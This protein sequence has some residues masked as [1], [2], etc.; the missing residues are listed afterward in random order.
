MNNAFFWVSECIAYIP[1]DTENATSIT[2]Y[3]HWN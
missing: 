3:I 1:L 2:N